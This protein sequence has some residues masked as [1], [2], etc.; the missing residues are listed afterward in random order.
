MVLGILETAGNIHTQKV[1]TI[2]PSL[3]TPIMINK[4]KESSTIVTIS[5]SSYRNL[6]KHFT[7]E[8]FDHIKDQYVNNGFTSNGI[9]G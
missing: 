5:Y 7:H 4:V 6:H 3:L 1:D 9:E 2:S 8:V